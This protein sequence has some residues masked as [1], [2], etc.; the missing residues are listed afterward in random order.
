M[1]YHII[2]CALHKDSTN[3]RPLT[4]GMVSKKYP[5]DHAFLGL[6]QPALIEQLLKIDASF[7]RGSDDGKGAEQAFTEFR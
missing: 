4:K 2:Y 7:H 3:H 6:A 5:D 1:R